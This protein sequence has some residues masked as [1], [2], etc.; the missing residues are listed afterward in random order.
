MQAVCLAAAFAR[1]KTGKSS[2]AKIAMMA[3]TTS[4]S[5]NVK[6]RFICIIVRRNERIRCKS[7]KVTNKGGKTV[8]QSAKI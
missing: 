4:N 8:R 7:S 3:I 1:A 2:A 5:I 6:A